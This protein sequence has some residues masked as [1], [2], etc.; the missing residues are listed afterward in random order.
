MGLQKYHQLGLKRHQLVPVKLSLKGV[1]GEG[2]TILGAVFLR[3]RGMSQDKEKRITAGLRAH[4]TDSTSNFYMSRKTMQDLG[5]LP[6][7]F[8]QVTSQVDSCESRA[9]VEGDKQ[10]EECTCPPHS[11]P[12]GAPSALP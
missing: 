8:P 2:I 5:I 12:P 9:K 6:R 10:S 1:N 4:V 7:N 3:V 11:Q